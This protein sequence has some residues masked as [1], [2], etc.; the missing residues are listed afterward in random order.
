VD[1]LQVTIVAEC[2]LLLAL[3][4]DIRARVVRLEGVDA[5]ARLEALERARR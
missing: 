1:P 3:V 4:Y 5:H 2:A